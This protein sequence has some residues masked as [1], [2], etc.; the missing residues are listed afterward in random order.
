MKSQINHTNEGAQARVNNQSSPKVGLLKLGYVTNLCT[1]KSELNKLL[2]DEKQVSTTELNTIVDGA[3]IV[4]LNRY[5]YDK[6]RSGEAVKQKD[7]TYLYFDTGLTNQTG[8][9]VIGWFE[10]KGKDNTFRGVNWGVKAALDV[11]ITKAK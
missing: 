2:A 9:H 5:G 8:E 11:K 10:R 6:T 1:C 7:A 3:C 4:Y